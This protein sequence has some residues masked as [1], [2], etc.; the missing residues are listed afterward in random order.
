MVLGELACLH[1][2]PQFV[3]K[4]LLRLLGVDRTKTKHCR[5]PALGIFTERGHGNT[6]FPDP[7]ILQDRGT[8]YTL[9]MLR[10]A[11]LGI[12]VHRT[13][14]H[15]PY[16]LR[17]LPLFFGET[18][19]D[20]ALGRRR[21]H[22]RTAHGRRAADEIADLFG[23]L[24][25]E[26]KRGNGDVHIVFSEVADRVVSVPRIPDIQVVAD[27]AIQVAVALAAGGQL[28]YFVTP[29]TRSPIP[30]S[31]RISVPAGVIERILC[32]APFEASA[33]QAPFAS[34]KQ[35]ERNNRNAHSVEMFLEHNG[36]RKKF[37]SFAAI[38]MKEASHAQEASRSI[39]KTHMHAPNVQ[40]LAEHSAD[41][42]D[43]CILR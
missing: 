7:I 35:R 8:S 3:G 13:G 21:Y 28:Q 26:L 9:V 12:S 24:A 39:Q 36:L 27:S 31:N 22:V 1:E 16:L 23:R 10:P 14:R 20:V 42:S 15:R 18:A 2:V 41:I 43:A 11:L 25:T 5:Q 17:A 40:W 32:G 29:T 6:K 38:T 37:A 34:K 4:S 33:A 19:S 30:R